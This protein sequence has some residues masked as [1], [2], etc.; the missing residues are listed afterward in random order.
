MQASAD[1]EST[2]FYANSTQ[3]PISCLVFNPNP[4]LNRRLNPPHLVCSREPVVSAHVEG[5]CLH[6]VSCTPEALIRHTTCWMFDKGGEGG[7]VVSCVVC[8]RV[9]VVIHKSAARLM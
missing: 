7:K 8:E 2:G 4:A 3:S 9:V 1:K 5:A 6:Q